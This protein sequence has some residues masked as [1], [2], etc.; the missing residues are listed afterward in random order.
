MI[1]NLNNKMKR[2]TLFSFIV[3]PGL[4][5]LAACAGPKAGFQS[6]EASRAEKIVSNKKLIVLDVRT[7][8]EYAEG[9]LP[10]AAN[11]DFLSSGFEKRLDSLDKSKKYLVYCR[12]GTRSA[13]A[14]EVMKKKGF[15]N[16]TNM[17]GGITAWQGKT[18]K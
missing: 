2:Q 11:L 16:V 4:A 15:Q 14:V 7:P 8:R 12:S 1:I 9:H 18:E 6:I 17:L 13:E 5:M 3:I 10:Q